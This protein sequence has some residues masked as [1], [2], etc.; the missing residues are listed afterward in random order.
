MKVFK[1][2]MVVLIT[3]L[4]CL[5]WSNSVEDDLF[6]MS[7]EEL[8]NIEVDSASKTAQKPMEAPSIISVLTQETLQTYA[9]NSLNEVLYRQPGFGPAQ[10]Y[11]RRTVSSRGMFEGWNNNHILHLVD[12]IPMNDNL[13]GT[14]YTWE[15]TPM[16]LIKTIEIIRGPGSALYGSNATNGVV[17]VK[18][19]S[20]DDLPGLGAMSLRIGD[21]GTEQFQA[22]AGYQNNGLALTVGV[23]SFDTDGVSYASFDGS[24]RMDE[25][26]RLLAF[27]VKDD[28]DSR[29]LWVKL[30][31]KEAMKGFS[32]QI[33]EQQWSFQTGHGWLWW[34][35]DYEESMNEKRKLVFL[36]YAPP[37]SGPWTPEF[38]LRYQRHEI[39]WNM[40]VYPDDAFDGFY[41]SGMWEY[42]RTDAEDLFARAQTHYQLAKNGSI[43]IGLEA[44]RFSYDGDKEHYSNINIDGDL[45][46][47]PGDRNQPLGPWLDFI[48]DKPIHY[49]GVFGQYTSGD[50]LGKNLSLTAGVRYDHMSVD[51]RN[52]YEVGAPEG[53]RSFSQVS[54]RLGLVY[55]PSENVSFKLLGGKAF[56]APTPTELAGAHTF[57]LGSNIEEL[58][59]EKI[60]T[61]E[62][63][64]DWI[65]NSHFNWRINFFRT[66]FENQI[67]YS[68][69]N[70]NLS[71]NIYTLTSAG[72]ETELFFV[73]QRVEGFFNVSLT[74]R[75][76]EEIIDTTIASS[77]DTLTWDPEEKVNFGVSYKGR[78]WRGAV[79]G[80][81]QGS[82]DRRLSDQG[83]QELP[84]GVGVTLD[85]DATRGSTVSSWMTMDVNATVDISKHV[86]CGVSIKN[87]LDEDV[88]L[89]K[90]IG[91][92]FDY[93]QA[94]RDLFAHLRWKF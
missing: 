21:R 33:H 9:W 6:N 41:P 5:I 54:P 92:P 67:A 7:L 90:N 55:M 48:K 94:G 81:V 80:H 74:D 47:F 63:A 16:F 45:A 75:L 39:D 88:Y 53:N 2:L 51:Y 43:L 78:R 30:E 18:T 83:F 25:E 70:N 85:M 20:P 19:I 10:D 59:P 86:S 40:R 87:V 15:N 68:A 42:L 28:Q 37:T 64:S 29:Y 24:G 79:Q 11:D 69:S 49:M 72:V 84:L 12:G 56:R 60:T 14:A 76:D 17:A 71:T 4:P 77:D 82:V 13:Y 46:P 38:S 93:R 89:V 26:G 73:Y 36:T 1:L 62:L 27:D 35:P 50:Q 8:L 34:I 22:L 57:S 3:G 52:V 61:L 58:D 66:K 31:G 32:M 91:F 23:H 65:I 44:D